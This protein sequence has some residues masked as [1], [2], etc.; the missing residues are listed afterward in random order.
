MDNITI[1]L[2]FM[3]Y[4]LY[5]HKYQLYM[6]KKDGF[7]GERSIVLPCT[8][9][10][11]IE[12]DPIASSIFITDI[13]YYPNAKHHY[14]KRLR[15]I[16]E[17]VFIYCVDGKGWYSLN[18]RKYDV[19]KDQYFILPAGIAHEYAADETEPWTIYWIH[20]RGTLARFYANDCIIPKDIKPNKQ[21]R[22]SNRLNL[23]E[24][25]FHTLNQSYAIENLR[26]AMVT[27]QHYLASL[28]YLQQYREAVEN[29]EPGD[30]VNMAIHFF[31]EN[32][33]RH[34]TLKSVS[35]FANISPS[36][37]STLFKQKIGYSPL[38]YFTLLKIKRA[39]ELLDT[40]SMKIN[41]ISVKLG[42]EDQYYFSRQFSNVM[43]M[44]PKSYRFRTKT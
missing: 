22:I 41:Q 30:A 29:S 28:R 27:F 14:R 13:G 38:N 23:F 25:I 44:S 18:G 20:F 32:I 10:K 35:E 2:L 16:D 3:L 9:I 33:E 34:L 21:S 17:Y 42:F 40:T 5:L 4:L 36:R 43:G 8:V 39:C 11:N 12:D 31:E 6:K 24:E 15:P 19:Q 26:Y 1:S 7:T 37:L